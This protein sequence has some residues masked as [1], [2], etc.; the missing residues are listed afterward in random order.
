MHLP[1]VTVAHTVCLD[2]LLSN[3][4][5]FTILERPLHCLTSGLTYIY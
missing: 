5:L 3:V 2:H 4:T 1:P